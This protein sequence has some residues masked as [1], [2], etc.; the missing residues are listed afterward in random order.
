M[1]TS[2]KEFFESSYLAAP[3]RDLELESLAVDQ[4]SLR[5]FFLGD[6][7]SLCSSIPISFES[8]ALGKLCF[9]PSRDD[10]ALQDLASL[11]GPLLAWKEISWAQKKELGQGLWQLYSENPSFDWVGIYRRDPQ[12]TSELIVSMYFGSPTPHERI[13]VERG[14][15]GAAIRD[16]Q[17]VYVPDVKVDARF[18][19]C[20]LSTKSELVVPIYDHNG[21]A[22]AEID[23]DCTEL[24][25]FSAEKIREV[26]SMASKFEKI[27]S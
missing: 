12:N 9:G 1:E 13:P 14:I 7:S 27:L 15:C 16:E 19:A 17:S 22:F 21:Q 4:D 8:T 23:I 6:P 10:K 25:G 2:E 3:F 26:E 20:S 11:L 5:L 24:N 18:L